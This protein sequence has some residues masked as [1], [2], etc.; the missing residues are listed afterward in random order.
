MDGT[1]DN[2]AWGTFLFL[3]ERLSMDGSER[4]GLSREQYDESVI[5]SP[6]STIVALELLQRMINDRDIP[7]PIYMFEDIYKTNYRRVLEWLLPTALDHKT[8]TWNFMCLTLGNIFRLKK[9]GSGDIGDIVT[10]Y[11]LR[12]QYNELHDWRRDYTFNLL[13]DERE[14]EIFKGM[15]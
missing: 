2:G 11:L 10:P 1:E 4:V 7:C 13:L 12:V 6:A 3:E 15:M 8:V 5:L 14:S 9:E